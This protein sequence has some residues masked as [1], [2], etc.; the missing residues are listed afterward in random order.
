MTDDTT[1]QHDVG[2]E[3]EARWYSVR[4]LIAASL[5]CLLLGLGAG[6]AYSTRKYSSR[7]QDR[8][9]F[10]EVDQGFVN[11]MLDHHDQ[12]VEMSLITLD[13]PGISAAV[14]HFA[15]EVVVFQRYE[16][17]LLEG[18][19]D[20]WGMERGAEDR[21]AMA[22]MGMRTNVAAM[23]GMASSEDLLR[24][25]SAT[26]VAADREFL[27][28]MRAHHKGGVHMAEFARDNASDAEVVVLATRMA[29]DQKL[30]VDEY[31]RTLDGLPKP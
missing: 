12:A 4:H 20:V 7:E 15:T 27:T 19:L 1:A 16:I 9:R 23:P 8:F 10:T 30:E 22:W 18:R 14:K 21:A 2:L 17:G 25:K 26:G 5:A 6:T 24:L 11:D 31:T 13:R 3:P 28:L 29:I